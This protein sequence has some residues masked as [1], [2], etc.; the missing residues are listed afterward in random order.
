M[1]AFPAAAEPTR[2]QRFK[3]FSI[4]HS[5][6][7]GQV[8]ASLGFLLGVILLT[9]SKGMEVFFSK[10]R[11]KGIKQTRG[12]WKRL[13]AGDK[14]T[15]LM[16]LGL[17]GSLGMLGGGAWWYAWGKKHLPKKQEREPGGKPGNQPRGL[18]LISVNGGGGDGPLG[19]E[20]LPGGRNRGFAPPKGTRP[21]QQKP[22]GPTFAGGHGRLGD[23]Q[24]TLPQRSESA[25]E[26]QRHGV[27]SFAGVRADNTKH[28]L[29]VEMKT[30]AE[31]TQFDTRWN[32]VSALREH[33]GHGILAEL[34]LETLPDDR[35]NWLSKNTKIKNIQ[36]WLMA[37]AGQR[38]FDDAGFKGKEKLLESLQR[39]EYVP[40]AG[41]WSNGVIEIPADAPCRLHSRKDLLET[42]VFC[43]QE[44]SRSGFIY[45]PAYEELCLALLCLLSGEEEKFVDVV[46]PWALSRYVLRTDRSN[47]SR[48]AI[49]GSAAAR[50]ATIVSSHAP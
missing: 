28:G 41:F 10:M 29:L 36:E 43:R 11:K 13:F 14:D 4:K 24:N 8:T 2:M 3:H 44:A 46:A 21:G 48:A 18:F 37:K 17:L 25:L 20:V 23:G 5:R 15:V 35:R 19:P 45:A 32:T 39:S 22:E 31:R 12:Y 40:A 27:L 34:T 30:D 6:G 38:A 1:H 42:I 9:S 47:P 33:P 49:L 26:A 50:R 7:G 16:T